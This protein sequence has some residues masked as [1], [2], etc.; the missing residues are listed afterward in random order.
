[1]EDCGGPYGFDELMKILADP[2]HCEYDDI[3]GWLG[4]S[5]WRSSDLRHINFRIKDAYRRPFA[6]AQE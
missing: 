3:V 1:M 2:D 5:K 6:T 4:T